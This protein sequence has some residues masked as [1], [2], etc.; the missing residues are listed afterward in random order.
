MLWTAPPPA[1]K[2]P[3]SGRRRG[4]RLTTAGRELLP[5]VRRNLIELLETLA[6]AREGARTYRGRIRIAAIPSTGS[7]VLP[8]LVRCFREHYPQA[9]FE[10]LDSIT[11]NPRIIELVL[12]GDIDMGLGNPPLPDQPVGFVELTRDRMC[13]AVDKT[14]PLARKRALTWAMVAREPLILTADRSYVRFLTDTTFAK[15]GISVR[16]AFEASLISTALG[17]VR[18][19]LG[20]AVLPE[21]ALRTGNIDGVDVKPLTQPSVH[22]PLGFLVAPNRV[23][24]PVAQKFIDLSRG[25]KTILGKAM[26]S[27]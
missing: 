16:P 18:A 19:G 27:R 8:L 25:A 23:L 20:V 6:Y 2:C 13:A 15:I 7:L 5:G 9:R 22:R 14:G 1:R 12:A 4:V 26:I 11:E 10:I 21:T 24:P 17:M 3:K